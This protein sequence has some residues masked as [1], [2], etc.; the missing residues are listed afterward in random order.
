MFAQQLRRLVTMLIAVTIPLTLGVV[1]APSANAVDYS[2][3]PRTTTW[4]PTDGRVY[5]VT[6]IDNTVFIGGSFTTLRNPA[7][8]STTS[9]SRLAAFDATTGALLP[10]NPGANGDV[11]ALEASSDG[12]GLFVGGTFTTIAGA[13]RNRLAEVSSTTGELVTGFSA[14]AGAAVLAIERVGTQLFVG[15]SFGTIK[16]TNHLRLAA[17]DEATGNPFAAFTGSADATVDTILA[18]PSGDR[19]FIG[20]AFRNLSGQGRNF[21]GAIQPTTGAATSWI[22]SAPCSDLQNLCEVLDLAQDSGKV[23]AGV[24]GPGGRVVAYDLTSGSRRWAAFGDGDVQAVAV[25]DNVV[26]AGGHFG[27]NFANQTRSG[28]VALSSTTGG[29]L[30]FA[31]QMTGNLGVWDILPDGDRLRVGGGF[32]RIDNSGARARYAEFDALTTAPDTTPPTAPTN[33]RTTN[34]T[35]TI[36]SFSWNASSDDTVVSGYRVL[37]DGAVV[38]S[39]GV[40]NYTDRNRT[41]NTTYTYEVQAT[42]AAGNWSDLSNPLVVTTQ[43]PS[44]SLVRSGSVWRYLSNGSDQGTAWRAP[45]FVDTSWSSGNAQ[46]GYGESDEATAISP[47]GLTHYFRQ[48][49]QVPD[50]AAI[51]ALN[52]RLL[53]DDGAV[54]YVNGV[55]VWRSNMPTGTLTFQTPAATEVTGNAESTYVNQAIPV[56]SLVNGT[57]TIAVEVHNV[58]GSDD[59]SFDLELI[60]TLAG[61]ALISTG[62]SWRYR[63]TSSAPAADWASPA[64]SDAGW[65]QGPSQ[66]GFGDGDEATPITRGAVSFYFR[67]TI[68]VADPSTLSTLSFQ[69]LRDD[70]AV[71]YVN[72]TEVNRSNLPAGT[73]AYG[74]LASSNISGTAERTYQSFSAPASLLVPG[75][76][77][78]AVEVH[79]DVASSSDVSMDLLLSGS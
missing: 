26:Y 3:T 69:L 42:D 50:V 76:N 29:A 18:A 34:L 31:P 68:T 37:R 40:T 27:P 35:D 21:I 6:R 54:V 47:L 39:I 9:R 77:V 20:G 10:W 28:I 41:P 57:N 38:T 75:A 23:Y 51:G 2:A 58:T 78:I 71:V 48:S 53:R 32:Q 11:R 56:S 70:G 61:N 43:P 67:R 46:L 55:E 79:Q 66:L 25:S 44:T 64:F 12:S 72:G 17:L 49:F 36:V 15:G 74:T 33:L 7:G 8:T 19:L 5:A 59:V 63:D 65:A 13:T 45:G 4:S 60:P 62:D 30:A 22:P 1:L 73:I 14:N 52:V 24:G 16:N